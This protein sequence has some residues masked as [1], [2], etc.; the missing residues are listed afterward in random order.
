MDNKQKLQN[1]GP[2]T[3]DKMRIVARWLHE[4]QGKDIKALNV[5]GIC[6]ITEGVV[7]AT[8]NNLR[9]GQALADF[10]LD[11]CDENK[12]PFSGMEGYKT[13]TW[14]LVDLNDVLVHIFQ[15]ESRGFYNLE[16][17]WSEAPELELDLPED[18]DD[19]DDFDD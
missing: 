3:E 17:L 4:K 13:G 10:V 8:A 1:L 11:M 14:L 5:E 18:E 2:N 16:G 19:E 9:H 7:L 12:I 15:G 6:S